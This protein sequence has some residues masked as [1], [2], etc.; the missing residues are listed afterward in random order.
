MS[1]PYL[2][3]S[4]PVATVSGYGEHARDILRS[5]RDSGK[6]EIEIVPQKWG[7]TPMNALSPSDE[8]HVWMLE[9]MRPM[10]PDGKLPLTK[11]PDIWIQVS[12]PNEFQPIGKWNV[13]ITAGIETTVVAAEWVLGMNRMDMNIVPSEHSKQSF[14]NAVYT[15]KDKNTGETSQVRMEKPIH[16]LFEGFDEEIYTNKTHQVHETILIDELSKVKEDFAYLF[17]GHWLKGDIGHDRK[18]VSTLIR[19]FC[20]TFKGQ[21]KKP[22]LILK[23]STGQFGVLDRENIINR[24]KKIKRE[25]GDDVPNVYLI[26][27][28][29]TNQEMNNLYNHEKVKT[30]ISFT[31]GEGFGRPLLEFTQ[32]GK[33]IIVSNWSGHLDFLDAKHT[34]LIGGELKNV[35]E[36]A[37]W[38]KVL[39][40]ES[41]W[42]YIDTEQAKKAI[43]E[44]YK[45]YKK[46]HILSKK[47][48]IQNKK[49]TLSKMTEK[50]VELFE[51]NQPEF[52]KEIELKLPKLEKLNG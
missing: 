16:V 31:K 32:S 8:F 46:Y 18:D 14:L 17:V 15:R 51:D 47:Q 21:K 28:E 42:F 26:H 35:H 20:E 27:G 48:M 33:P 49:F 36:S 4:A 9:R 37:A 44:V 19:T 1:K 25:V 34:L 23:T 29:L 22:A 24:I 45:N 3:Y 12:V 39:L 13:G 2:V 11:Q 50:L 40:K 43:K 7:S 10:Q 41:K 5:L 38:E 30:M 6:Y 52:P